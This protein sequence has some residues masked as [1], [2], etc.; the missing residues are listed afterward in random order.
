MNSLRLPILAE[1]ARI[2][3]AIAISI[4]AS[5]SE[6]NMGGCVLDSFRSFL[7]PLMVDALVCTQDWLQKSNDAMNLEDYVDELQTMED[8]VSSLPKGV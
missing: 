7:T 5:K 3:L 8:D 4:V 6:F 1:M 2:I